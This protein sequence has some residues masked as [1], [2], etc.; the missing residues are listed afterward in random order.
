[1]DKVRLAE[2]CN[3]KFGKAFTRISN[4]LRAHSL[5]FVEW[6]K[7]ENAQATIIHVVGGEE[8]EQALNLKNAIVVQHCV[9][10]PGIT[11][12]GWVKLW[13][14]SLLTISFHDLHS[15]SDDNFN[16]LHV[17]W[18]AEP[19]L[20]YRE[21]NL[22]KDYQI[23]STGHVAI[24]ENLD[25]IHKA[26]QK[27][28]S[29]FYHTGENFNWSPITYKYLK[30]MPDADLRRMLNRAKYVGCLRE[31]EGFELMGI[32]GAFCG[33]RPIIP[34][35]PTYQWYKDFGCFIDMSRD[36][37]EQLI[38]LFNSPYQEFTDEE[39]QKIVDKFSWKPIT[40]DIFNA[41]F[42]TLG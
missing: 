30:Y 21:P 36:V 17:P 16:S 18:G 15:Y 25:K 31:V 22:Q 39:R 9:A 19:S 41:I 12:E 11:I 7:P 5:D 40:L 33:A 26:C 28:N 24:T 8:Y 38:A 10:M 35:L 29:I 34:N 27:T 3:P 32:E 20:F 13:K 37:V 4:A 2:I 6:V 14:S 1:M 42:K 23:F